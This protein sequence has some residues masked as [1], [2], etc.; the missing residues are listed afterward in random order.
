MI[1]V[2]LNVAQPMRFDFGFG[3]RNSNILTASDIF[4]HKNIS[5]RIF[6]WIIMVLYICIIEY[7]RWPKCMLYSLKAIGKGT[8]GNSK[9]KIHIIVLQ[10]F[11]LYLRRFVVFV[12]VVAA[13]QQWRWCCLNFVSENPWICFNERGKNVWYSLFFFHIKLTHIR[14]IKHWKLFI[15][16]FLFSLL[17]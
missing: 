15:F 9:K 5:V 16:L 1:Y 12:V 8:I 6:K 2:P 7:F 17:C 3:N 10:I 11:V 14:I 13:C 4:D